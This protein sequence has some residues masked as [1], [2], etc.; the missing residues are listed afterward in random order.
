MKKTILG[1][2]L[3]ILIACSAILLLG[4]SIQHETT[5][6][7]IEVP[8]RVYKGDD[9]VDSLTIDD[10]EVY[11][12]GE[13]QTLEAVYLIKKTSIERKDENRT[14][15]PDIGRHFYL[16]FE[17]GEYDPKIR[18]GIEYF[19]KEVLLP[20]DELIIVTPMR[21]YRMKSETFQVIGRG[22]VYDDLMGLLRRDILMGT[23]EYRATLEDLKGLA[24]SLTAELALADESTLNAMES[25]DP[26]STSAGL[27]RD[28]PSFEERL[29]IYLMYLNRLENLRIV[30]ESRLTNFATYLKN[31]P[32]QKE[33][34]LFYQ[35]EFLPK[36]EPKVLT[37]YMSL[38]NDRPDLIQTISGLFE[39][40]R[41]DSTLNIDFVKK[42]FSDSSAAVHFLYITRPADRIPGIV[43]EEQS[44]DVF[45][46]FSEMSRATGG[47]SSTSANVEFSMKAA[48]AASE[49]YYLLYYVPKNYRLDGRFH[50]LQI[51]VKSGNFRVSHRLGYIAD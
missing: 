50:N 48:V 46:A 27:F 18:T 38:F 1:V 40:F 8:V 21:P 33:V 47:F 26:F 42:A 10:F 39:F 7:N 13:L 35:R 43:M 3:A 28:G 2:G 23:A 20:E 5:A 17:M 41:R 51:K 32:G 29:Q 4:Q 6:I 37:A 12:D 24:Q 22:R 34:F 44:E 11:D 15:L 45:A 25:F 31:Q 49:N 19:V 36:I 9:F 16:F 14:F 30:E